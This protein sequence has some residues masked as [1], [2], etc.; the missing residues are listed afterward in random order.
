MITS[1]SH[2]KII[3]VSQDG[4]ILWIKDVSTN[5]IGILFSTLGVYVVSLRDSLL[6]LDK[7]GNIL[8]SVSGFSVSSS[9]LGKN[10]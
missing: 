4:E 6:F 3:K 9:V 5:P 10:I 7:D 8:K 1:Y 2:K